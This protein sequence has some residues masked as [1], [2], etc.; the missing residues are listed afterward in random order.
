MPSIYSNILKKKKFEGG[1][2]C[3]PSQ[4]LPLSLCVCVYNLLDIT[5][6]ENG[7]N[8]RYS[9]RGAN[10][11]IRIFDKWFFFLTQLNI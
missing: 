4:R 6:V 2:H 3:P 10:W 1:G 11:V 5:M 7:W 9:Q 8:P